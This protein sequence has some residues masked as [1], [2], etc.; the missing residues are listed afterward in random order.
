VRRRGGGREGGW[1]G[2][3]EGDKREE[4]RE[5]RTISKISFIRSSIDIRV[6]VFTVLRKSHITCHLHVKNSR[7]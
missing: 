1:R 2:E 5:G 3:N 7:N 6:S 4:E